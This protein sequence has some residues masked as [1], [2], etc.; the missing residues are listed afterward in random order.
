MI[1]TTDEIRTT[2]RISSNIPKLSI[3]LFHNYYVMQRYCVGIVANV[4]RYVHVADCFAVAWVFAIV[5]DVEIF[6]VHEIIEKCKN[7]DKQLTH[8]VRLSSWGYFITSKRSEFITFTQ[9][10]TKSFTNFSL[11]SSYA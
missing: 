4:R 7:H 5:L 2:S 3:K 1:T 11:L 6:Q 9:A 8:I 10:L